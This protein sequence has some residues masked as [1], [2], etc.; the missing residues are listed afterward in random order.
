MAKSIQ[1]PTCGNKH[2]VTSLPDAASFRCKKCG[3]SLK[4]PAQ[5]R[6]SM[7]AAR[8]SPPPGAPRGGDATAVLSD[9]RARA[10]APAAAPRAPRVA[11]A[12]AAASVEGAQ[13]VPR[14]WRAVAWVAALLL[15][16]AVTI[17]LGRVTDWLSGDHL[18]DIFTGTGFARYIRIVAIAPVSALFTALFLTLFLEGGQALARRRAEKRA[19][20]RDA[21][22]GLLRR[23][24]RPL[25]SDEAAGRRSGRAEDGGRSKTAA[26][27]GSS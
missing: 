25:E 19:E 8:R 4:I 10:P 11:R 2:S 17:W 24:S 5:F 21:R 22:R 26:Q 20:E 18:V 9:D 27:R 3:Q 15:G 16:L 1:C 6:P 23:R 14:Q 7:E 12:T 13:A